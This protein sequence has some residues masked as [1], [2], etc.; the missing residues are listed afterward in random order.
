M[1][2]PANLGLQ[3]ETKH[4]KWC[5]SFGSEVTVRQSCGAPDATTV[6]WKRAWGG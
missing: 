6:Y 1:A 4:F 3:G 5:V 2:H